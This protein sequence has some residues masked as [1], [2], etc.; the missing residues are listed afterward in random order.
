[1]WNT[2]CNSSLQKRFTKLQRTVMK[3]QSRDTK[4]QRKNTIHQNL[5]YDCLTNF[6]Y[7]HLD[8]HS[9]SVLKFK[10]TARGD[11]QS[12]SWHDLQIFGNRVS[13]NGEIFV[14]EESSS[15]YKGLLRGAESAE[16]L[17]NP[18]DVGVAL[19]ADGG[20][21]VDADDGVRVSIELK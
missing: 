8:N 2:K 18:G 1:M 21:G 17:L 19:I 15:D 14:L 16:E 9:N 5:R 12:G 11:G 10:N 4:I 7:A 6:S 20:E 13:S 3:L